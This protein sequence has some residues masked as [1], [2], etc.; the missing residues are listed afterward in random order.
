MS[1]IRLA[2]GSAIMPW[3]TSV[4]S[5]DLDRSKHL[6]DL[7]FL[8]RA[9]YSELVIPRC[10]LPGGAANQLSLKIHVGGLS[11]RWYLANKPQSYEKCA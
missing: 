2:R 7:S 1:S 6:V 3:Q 11:R 8:P 9:G 5:L 10:D 4:A